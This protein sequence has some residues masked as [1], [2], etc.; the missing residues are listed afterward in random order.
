MDVCPQT[1]G[2]AKVFLVWLVVQSCLVQ[3]MYAAHQ[4]VLFSKTSW[5]L[6]HAAAAGPSTGL[7]LFLAT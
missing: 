5:S 6:S 3:Q 4:R 7:V 2:Y 1:V